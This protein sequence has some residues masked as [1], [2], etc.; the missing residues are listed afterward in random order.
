MVQVENEYGSL[1]D[2]S[3]EYRIWARDETAKY[4]QDK[5]VL[6]TNDASTVVKCG[7]IDGVLATLDFGPEPDEDLPKNWEQLRKYQPQGPLVNMEYYPG[8]LTH[9]QEPYE[10]Q[11]TEPT[12]QSLRTMLRANASINF[13]MFYGGTNFGFTAGIV[14]V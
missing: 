11:E 5:A 7:K 1:R 3:Q 6:F 14:L 8:W 13:Y 12:V 9:W 2:C 4:V 10:R